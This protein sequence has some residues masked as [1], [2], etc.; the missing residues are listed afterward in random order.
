MVVDLKEAPMKIVKMVYQTQR[1]LNRMWGPGEICA[2]LIVFVYLVKKKKNSVWHYF[3][4]S[5]QCGRKSG[6]LFSLCELLG[7]SRQKQKT[8]E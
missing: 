6:T 1:F 2:Q 7:V 8:Q 5:I 4:F 3:R